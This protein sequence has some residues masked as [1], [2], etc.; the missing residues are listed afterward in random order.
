MQQ[1]N[2][3][4]FD[5][6]FEEF[7]FEKQAKPI[8]TL[9]REI[10]K[11]VYDPEAIE[12]KLRDAI[13]TLYLHKLKL[14][15]Y[16]GLWRDYYSYLLE[17]IYKMFFKDLTESLN[18]ETYVDIFKKI[19]MILSDEHVKVTLFSE[20]GRHVQMV[21]GFA[22]NISI[23]SEDLEVIYLTGSQFRDKKKHLT[24][25]Y[26]TNDKNRTLRMLGD[27]TKIFSEL[28][29]MKEIRFYYNKDEN[30]ELYKSILKSNFV[31][32][33]VLSCDLEAI[34]KDHILLD[35]LNEMAA[36][37]NLKVKETSSRIIYNSLMGYFDRISIAGL[38]MCFGEKDSNNPFHG[39]RRNRM[40]EVLVE[41]MV[42]NVLPKI[43]EVEIHIKQLK[44]SSGDYAA[45][46]ELKKNIPQKV[47]DR[48]NNS[49]LLEF[50]ANIEYD[51]LV[52]LENVTQFEREIISFIKTF[53]VPV[54]NNATFKVRRLGKIKAA[55]VFYPFFNTLAVDIHHPNSF[56]HEFWH[57]IDY[58][59]K[60]NLDEFTGQ[61]LSSRRDFE[62]I[63]KMYKESVNSAILNLSLESLVRIKFF[64]KTKYNKDYYFDNTEI[65]ARCA[66]IYFSNALN[67]KSSLVEGEE[68]VYYPKDKNL[69]E[70][71]DEYFTKLLEGVGHENQITAA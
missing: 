14:K 17:K 13:G 71:I 5:T 1:L 35:C 56:I 33:G 43:N 70:L 39:I 37:E 34:A 59:Q 52:D 64:G 48:M 44:K 11:R 54:P 31:Y 42:T 21:K 46:Y 51:E 63:I 3:F 60:D 55:G 24:R 10:K 49:S 26:F 8:R 40:Y 61:R 25:R 47:L 20:T 16:Q 19:E 18:K 28:L 69:R 23:M 30:K 50:F 32:S 67:G 12:E 45:T 68:S 66:E 58:Y 41:E 15:E 29:L 65:F 36:L 62:G 9:K 22:F 2:L 53:K 6:N 7:I 57:M 27:V 38:Q 4:D